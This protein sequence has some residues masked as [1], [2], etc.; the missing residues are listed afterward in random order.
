M[1]N[2][3][4]K[5]LIFFSFFK[6]TFGDTWAVLVD[7]SKF[8]FNYRHTVNT[9]MFYQMLKRFGL[10]DE[11]IIL[12]LPENHQCHPRNL[13]PGRIEDSFH[14]EDLM[15][16]V[17]ID[18]RGAE[19]SPESI[20]QVLTGRHSPGTPYSKRLE[21]RGSSK[22]FLYLTGHGGNGY[23]KVQDTQV[24]LSNDL[25]NAVYEMFYKERFEEMMIFI[26]SCQALPIF[27]YIDL[28]GVHGL[29]SS[30]NG[31]PAKSYGTHRELGVSATDHFSYY[32][33]EIFNKK[34]LTHQVDLETVI[35][36]L[37]KNLIKSQIG[38]KSRTKTSHIIVNDFISDRFD[39]ISVN[40]SFF[41][42]RNPKVW[43]YLRV[44]D[45]E[46]GKDCEEEVMDRDGNWNFFVSCFVGLVFLAVGIR[47]R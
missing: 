27:D 12:M 24:L 32:F 13:Y 2:F 33:V 35:K 37:P 42:Y 25:A 47:N 14:S 21:S 9:L 36:K 19:V 41:E 16:D 3:C 20:V 11:H 40:R 43:N 7:S 30:L 26:D 22:V 5:F 18:Y 10:D 44:E 45:R 46:K 23:F 15:N 28:P 1:K 31:Q 34:N 17:E 38:V 8:Y 4:I 39:Q 6:V 29:S